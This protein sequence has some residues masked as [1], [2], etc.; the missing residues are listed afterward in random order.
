MALTDFLAFEPFNELRQRMSA[1]ELGQFE[2][3]NPDWH[4]TGQERSQLA[5]VGLTVGAD[6]VQMLLDF[7][8]V[9]K[10]SRILVADQQYFHL[11]SC[12]AL[13]PRSEYFITTSLRGAPSG[14]TVCPHCLQRLTYDG[15]DMT[16]A[17]RENYS[18]RV[19]DTFRLTDFWQ[20]YPQYPVSEKREM[21]RTLECVDDI[22]KS[23]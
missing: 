3:F 11:A 5:R 13:K 14:L 8:L 20:R 10:N 12:S 23:S 21:R 19:R 1:S 16:K 17:R 18:Q 22:K 15:Y 4:L 2:L 9:Y 7:T 6:K